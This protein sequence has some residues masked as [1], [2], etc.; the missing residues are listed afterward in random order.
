MATKLEQ[1]TPAGSAFKFIGKTTLKNLLIEVRQLQE[2]GA[3]AHGKLGELL[4][5]AEDSKNLH[6]PSFM[7]A[8]RLER[9]EGSKLRTFLAH[10]DFY[11]E[12]FQLDKRASEQGDFIADEEEA[13]AAEAKTAAAKKPAKAKSGEAK[14]AKPR[15]RKTMGEL[16][17]EPGAPFAEGTATDPT[18]SAP[19]EPPAPGQELQA[20]MH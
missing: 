15:K 14:E 19:A 5:N 18:G 12:A 9:Q 10:F 16:M 7:L 13:A 17:K 8:Q 2:K 6:R 11:R 3:A 4:K 1:P 20:A